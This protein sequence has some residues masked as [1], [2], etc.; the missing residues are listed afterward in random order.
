M[1]PIDLRVIRILCRPQLGPSALT[2]LQFLNMAS[3]F[4]R[5]FNLICMM[6][7]IGHWSGCLQFLVP[8][9]QGFPSNS[10][11]AINEL[12]VRRIVRTER[13]KLIRNNSPTQ[14]TFQ[15]A[16]WLEQYS[17]A[18]FKAMSH[19]LCIGYGRYDPC[20]PGRGRVFL[21]LFQI[22]QCSAL[23]Q[24]FVRPFVERRKVFRLFYPTK[25][26]CIAIVSPNP[27]PYEPAGNPE[28]GLTKLSDGLAVGRAQVSRIPETDSGLQSEK[29]IIM[30]KKVEFTLTNA[31][32]L[33]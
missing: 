7:L 19:M 12:Q 3:V 13:G 6:L 5:I 10:W 31:V 15:E 8:M 33:P 14:F 17:W 25:E 11:V 29:K 24:S 9:L 23:P 32:L 30:Q 21:L 27:D 16:Y 2:S 26:G 22:R 4:M 1:P 28:L 20:G 18:L